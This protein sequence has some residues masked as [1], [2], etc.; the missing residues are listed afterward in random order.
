MGM[1][2][3]SAGEANQ[4]FSRLLGKAASGEEVVID[5]A[6]APEPT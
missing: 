1:T 4:L 2:T 6:L 5:R 3:V